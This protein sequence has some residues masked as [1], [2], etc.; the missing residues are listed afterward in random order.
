MIPVDIET[1][2]LLLSALLIMRTPERARAISTVHQDWFVDEW[3]QWLFTTMKMARDCDDE[4]LLGTL[5]EG[6]WGYFWPWMKRLIECDAGKVKVW[7][8]YAA[9]LQE[10]AGQ[11]K[12][13]KH[14]LDELERLSDDAAAVRFHP[15]RH[16]I[17]H[18]GSTG[19]RP[20]PLSDGALASR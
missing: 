13:I 6:R 19:S 3:H 15:I 5:S 18:G 9:R 10:F 17:L 1:E 7:R 14:H 16:E 11:R 20:H 4:R 12:K 8:V 2:R